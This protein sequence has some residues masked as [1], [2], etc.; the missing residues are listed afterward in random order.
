MRVEG[1]LELVGVIDKERTRYV[2]SFLDGS[3]LTT[4]GCI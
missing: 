3:K 4:L 2:L 1:D